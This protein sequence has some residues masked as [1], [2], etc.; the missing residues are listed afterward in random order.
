MK[1]LTTISLSFLIIGIS[2]GSFLL[3]TRGV[4]ADDTA[5]STDPNDPSA[6]WA[7]YPDSDA[8]GNPTQSCGFGHW[9]A[10]EVCSYDAG[11]ASDCHNVFDPNPP[12][13]SELFVPVLQDLMNRASLSLSATV[14]KGMLSW[15]YGTIATSSPSMRTLIHM[16]GPYPFSELLSTATLTLDLY[17]GVA[18]SSTLMYS[19]PILASTTSASFPFVPDAGA[20]YFMALSATYP[21]GSYPPGQGPAE[22]CPNNGAG[23]GDFCIVPTYPLS[24]FQNALTTGYNLIEQSNESLGNY[25]PA[26]YGILELTIPVAPPAAAPVSNVLFIPGTLTSRLYMK[27]ANGTERDLW[28]PRSDLDVG[29]LAMSADGKSLNT[30]YT[31]D[32]VDQLYSNSS[33]YGAA[34]KQTLGTGINVYGPFE[35]FMNSLV[36]N[37]TLKEWHAYPYDWRYDVSDIVKNGTLVA[38]AAVT[39]SRVYLQDVIQQLAST[40]PT[41]KVTI[42]AHSNG[43][44]IAKALAIDLQSKGKSALIDHIIMVGTPQFGTPKSVLDMLHGSEF[45]ELGGLL[46]YSGSV[47]AAEET[48]PGPYDLLP[49]P[50]YFSQITT[51]VATFDKQQPATLYQKRFGSVIDSFS[52]LTDFVEDTFHINGSVGLPGSTRT[53]IALSKSFVQKAEAT[54]AATDSWTP[55]PGISVTAIAGWGQLTPYQIAYSG[56]RGLNCDRTSFFVPIACSLQPQLQNTTLSTENG[57]DTVVAGSAVGIATDTLYFNAKDYEKDTKND[58]V[59]A[60]LLNSMPVQTQLVD[61]L[62]SNP[63]KEPYVSATIPSEPQSSL[64]IVSAHSPVNLLATDPDGNQTGIVTIPGLS[65]ISFEKKDIPG[66]SIQ[67]VD[68]EKYLYL[69]TDANYTI[70]VQGYDSGV[71]TINVGTMNANGISTTTET[72][73]DIP[74]TASTTASFVIGAQAVAPSTISIDVD[75]NGSTTLITANTA[76]TTDQNYRSSLFTFR[77]LLASHKLSGALKALLLKLFKDFAGQKNSNPLLYLTFQALVGAQAGVKLLFPPQ[78]MLIQL[79]HALGV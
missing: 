34:A 12:S 16:N 72:F 74:T 73:S 18:G 3:A 60:N 24:D 46:M 79:I 22:H 8:D 21:D 48:M 63:K 38:T 39:P 26:A 7:C 25:V 32:L 66:S 10:Q 54:H 61:E 20:S 42:V 51:P 36:T 5:T 76:S 37:G 6:V 69:P 52:K 23:G 62:Q 14:Q 19:Q 1:S 11:V 49:S 77:A 33:L 4:H 41:G 45:T 13:A 67:V 31:R 15:N 59:H 35:S 40:S 30:I 58:V 70:G 17:K 2:L 47:R 29:P 44:L 53:P 65:G 78:N 27:N 55:P 56:T 71:T 9:E 50:G 57:D 64:T 68:D 75:G 43:G 28:E